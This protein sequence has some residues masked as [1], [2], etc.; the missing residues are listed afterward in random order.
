MVSKYLELQ[1]GERN[2]DNL[3][4]Q[5]DEILNVLAQKY[6]DLKKEEI[7]TYL[8]MYSGLSHLEYREREQLL[9]KHSKR[10]DTRN[11]YHVASYLAS[12]SF[13]SATKL[14]VLAECILS[15]TADEALA[16]GGKF[17]TDAINKIDKASVILDRVS[18]PAKIAALANIQERQIE[19]SEEAPQFHMNLLEMHKPLIESKKKIVK[20]GKK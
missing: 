1:A 14:N 9:L 5:H 17:D 13:N 19:L 7:S 15:Q 8:G 18:N 4:K 11:K 3:R 20:I 6:P 10:A 12:K 16:N 2:A